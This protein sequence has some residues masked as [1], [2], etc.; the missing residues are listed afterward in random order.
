MQLLPDRNFR[1]N[2]KKRYDSN[3]EKLMERKEKRLAQK[4]SR[5]S[6]TLKQT[7]LGSIV[8]VCVFSFLGI[9]GLNISNL[10]NER[11]LSISELTE[12]IQACNEAIK[13]FQIVDTDAKEQQAKEALAYVTNIQN[14][15]LNN[16]YDADYD[17]YA[18]RYLGEYNA[19]WSANCDALIKAVW[20]GYI[21]FAYDDTQTTRMCFILSDNG[22]PV[23]TVVLYYTVDRFGN[24]ET[25]TRMD[26]MNFL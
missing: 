18:I 7:L 2:Y 14:L 11:E 20:S 21:D 16:N 15:Y 13:Q 22:C 24:L 12:K 17:I 26:E 1:S 25:V 5:T 10:Y 4:A 23:K 9:I 8:C 3:F 19:D 6:N